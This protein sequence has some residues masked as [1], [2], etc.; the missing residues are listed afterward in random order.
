MSRGGL[1][2]QFTAILSP[3]ERLRS[4]YLTEDETEKLKQLQDVLAVHQIWKRWKSK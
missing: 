1:L 2:E 4:R 3:S